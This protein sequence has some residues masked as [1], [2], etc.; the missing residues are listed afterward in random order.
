MTKREL[1]RDLANVPGVRTGFHVPD[2]NESRIV[3]TGQAGSGKS[4]LLNANPGL[5]MLD[6]ERGGDT[7][8]EP[9]AMRF[10]PAPSVPVA[11]LDL[12]YQEMVKRIIERH[13]R[14]ARDIRMIGVDSL[15][16]LILIFQTALKLREGVSDVGD[17]GGGHGKGYFIVR[18]AIFGML[19][20][21][22]RA[23]LGWA[24]IV[25][26]KFKIV[27]VG[28]KEQQ[29][30]VLAISDSYKTAT[31]QKCE[32]MLFLEKG[33]QVRTIPGGVKKVR[34]REVKEKPRTETI[35]VRKLRTE[36]GGLL[37]G[38]SAED[39]KARLPLPNEI[40][41]PPNGGWETWAAAYQKA[42]RTLTG[43]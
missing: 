10:T 39:V 18:D 40:M 8:A 29:Q 21:V 9:L 27:K 15:D 11:E 1:P 7:V 41:I 43:E 4:T 26:T 13:K 2:V 34:G 16:E 20:E 14:G 37:R 22:Y 17:I 19:D 38:G 12:A 30:S 23:G 5:F 33:V 31:F 32:H 42:A 6:P 35:P 28:D 24:L 25:H 3:I 36:P